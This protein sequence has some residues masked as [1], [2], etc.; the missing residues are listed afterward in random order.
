MMA[1]VMM[2]FIAHHCDRFYRRT[3]QLMSSTPSSSPF[4]DAP[5]PVEWLAW[6]AVLV[7]VMLGL[8]EW[9]GPAVASPLA[10]WVTVVGVYALLVGFLAHHQAVSGL[11]GR[12]TLV[13][14]LITI[15]LLGFLWSPNAYQIFGFELGLMGLM[16]LLLDGLDGHLARRRAETTRAGARF[17]METDAAMIL[18]LSVAVWL[19]GRAEAWV[20][21]M[22]ALRYVFV[23]SAWLWPWMG[24]PLPDSLRRKVICVV[25]VSVL[26][27][28]LPMW[29]PDLMATA[30]LLIGLALLLYSFGV[31]TLWLWTHRHKRGVVK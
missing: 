5:G 3:V 7:G 19:S 22:G 24:Q 23:A 16:A 14:A 13:R 21:L 28:V 25:Q 30:V 12:I 2:V 26:L 6:S 20:L 29:L 10:V 15:A 18:V 11:A 17:D 31:D 1:L 27:L 4:A 8:S 9:M